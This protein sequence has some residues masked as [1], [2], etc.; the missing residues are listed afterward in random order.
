MQT[1]YKD[2]KLTIRFRDIQVVQ[3]TTKGIDIKRECFEVFTNAFKF[4]VGDE[5]KDKFSKEY[6]EY[7]KNVEE[8]Y[9]I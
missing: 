2:N 6:E 7:L 4:T 5:N 9:N 8:G 3:K 1:Y